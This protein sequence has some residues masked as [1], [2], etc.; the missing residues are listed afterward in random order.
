MPLRPGSWVIVTFSL[1]DAD[2]SDAPYT[3]YEDSFDT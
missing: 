3:G 2:D 1:A